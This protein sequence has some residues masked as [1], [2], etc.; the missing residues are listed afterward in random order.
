MR[1]FEPVPLCIA[2]GVREPVRTREIHDDRV[3]GRHE[4]GCPL[5]AEATENDVRARRECVVV[6]DEWRQ[7]EASQP[8]IEH[9]SAPAGKRFRAERDEFQLGMDENAVERFLTGVT[10]RTE[11][12]D[13]VHGCVVCIDE[14]CYALPRSHADGRSSAPTSVCL[15][16]ALL[17]VGD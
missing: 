10:R 9:V 3:D 13:S 16:A 14:A 15:P 6:R 8:R 4:R 5:V 1:V 7:V 2:R 11:D 12:R 17:R